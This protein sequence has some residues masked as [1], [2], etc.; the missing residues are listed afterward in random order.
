MIL[1]DQLPIIQS[2]PDPDSIRFRL[3]Q[4]AR[5]RRVL[6]SLLSVSRSVRES[7]ERDR[8]QAP[9]EGGDRNAL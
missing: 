5:E 2:I 9:Q 8:Q 7:L 4:I 3:A 6:R 1:L